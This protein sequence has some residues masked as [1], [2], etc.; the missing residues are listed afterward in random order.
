ME[1]DDW[2]KVVAEGK[3]VKGLYFQKEKGK[4]KETPHFQGFIRTENAVSMSGIKKKLKDK[5]VHVEIMRGTIQQSKEYCS[6]EEGRIDGPWSFG[7]VT[8]EPGKRNDI[9]KAIEIIKENPYT[10]DKL[11]EEVP[12]LVSRYGR[13]IQLMQSILQKEQSNKWRDVKVN[14]RYGEAGVG[15]TKW[16][17][18]DYK[19]V[20]NLP[21]PSGVVWFNGYNGETTLILDDFTGWI[22][23]HD[24]LR[25]VDG[26]PYMGQTKGG[27]IYANWTEVRITSNKSPDNWWKGVTVKDNKEF[28]RRITT[29]NEKSVADWMSE[30][31]EKIV[32]DKGDFYTIV[33]P[34]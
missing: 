22:K 31:P 14:I 9:V 8:P 10:M 19:D 3:G 6:K 16:A 23:Y 11:M 18:G 5:T 28:R 7:D 27:F 25:L 33:A 26:Y 30:E 29:I 1:G 20:Y 4:E 17:M 21:H 24:W 15:K 13:G 2:G 32:G 34:S 12:T